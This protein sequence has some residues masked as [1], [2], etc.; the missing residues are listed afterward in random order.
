MIWTPTSS[1]CIVGG[2]FTPKFRVTGRTEADGYCEVSLHNIAPKQDVPALGIP[3]HSRPDFITLSLAPE[4][5]ANFP[6][7]AEF[8]LVPAATQR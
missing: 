7:G 8:E 5:F 4:E 2:M 3:P 6:V 1:R